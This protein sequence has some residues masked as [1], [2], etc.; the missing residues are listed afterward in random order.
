MKQQRGELLFSR[1]ELGQWRILLERRIDWLRSQKIPYRFLVAP[2]PHSAYPEMLPF[3]VASETPRPATQLIEYLKETGSSAQVIY[4]LD[5]LVESRD[6][7]IFTKTNTHW[8]D[9]GA[10]LAYE[11][12][13]DEI[14]GSLGVRRISETDLWFHE[15]VQPG[16]L[17]YK[18]E[19]HECS[20]HIFGIIKKPKAQIKEDN[21]VQL[22][23]HRIDYECAEAGAAVCLAFGDSFAHMMLPFLAESFGQLVFAHLYTL[24]RE[25]VAQVKPDVVVSIMNERFII[26]VPNDDEGKTLQQ[27][28]EEKRAKGAVYPPRAGSGTR[29]DTP[30]PWRQ[31]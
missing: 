20:V 5:R 11:V 25:L 28:A 9:L 15:H 16:D 7:P 12:L 26:K 27:W 24:D 29:V 6:R 19:P 22:N 23:G 2:N 18:V 21:R 31:D 4:P 30:A 3:D 8:T 17:G 1:D 13:M 14:A 10:F